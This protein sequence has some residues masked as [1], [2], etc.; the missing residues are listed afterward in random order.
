MFTS[1]LTSICTLHLYFTS[2]DESK[3][4]PRSDGCPESL[5]EPL[6]HPESGGGGTRDQCCLSQRGEAWHP[7]IFQCDA[8]KARAGARD[9]HAESLMT[10][11]REGETR[12]EDRVIGT[13]SRSSRIDLLSSIP[14]TDSDDGLRLGNAIGAAVYG[15]RGE[16]REK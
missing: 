9:H 13:L 7:G 4:Q 15:P 1:H 16:W 5:P 8:G 11:K 2:P 6:S 12:N 14:E 3:S 10:A